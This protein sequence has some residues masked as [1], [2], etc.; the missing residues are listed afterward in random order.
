[1]QNQANKTVLAV[2]SDLF[3]SAKINEAAKRAGVT[4]E[5]VT[6]EKNVF[7][8]AQSNPALIIFDL[9]FDAVHPVELIGK[10]KGNPA[11]KHISLLGYLSHVQAEL[12]I[13]AQEAGCD[14]VMPRSAFSMNLP[15]I[16]SSVLTATPR[17]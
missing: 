8:K 12:K 4:L 6:M 17:T 14:V 16:L 7:E 5:Y 1:M 15:Q 2:V 10:L 3:F 9:N 11:L 13:R